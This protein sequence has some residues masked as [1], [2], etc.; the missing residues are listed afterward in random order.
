MSLRDG[1]ELQIV[2]P[3]KKLGCFI[4]AIY[5]KMHA[6]S[7]WERAKLMGDLLRYFLVVKQLDMANM[8]V[9][10]TKHKHGK[11]G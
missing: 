5:A 9:F 11:E 3:G 7:C 8:P 2:S 4:S 6:I 1:E 10:F